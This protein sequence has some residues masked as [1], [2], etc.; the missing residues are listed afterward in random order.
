MAS[1][2]LMAI[3]AAWIAGAPVPA[4]DP[5]VEGSP[6]AGESSPGQPAIASEWTVPPD[7]TSGPKASA[8]LPPCQTPTATRCDPSGLSGPAGPNEFAAC[9]GSGSA[10]IGA[11][12]IDIGDLSLIQPMGL[13]IGGHVTPIDHG[14]F[15]IKGSTEA[16]PRRA[17][18]R[19]PFAGVITAVSR[20]TRQGGIDGAFDDY[21][22]TIEATCTFRARFSNMTG[23]TGGLQAAVGDL[24][25]GRSATPDYHVVE[26]EL[27][28]FTGLPTAYGIDV[29]IEDDDA[30]LTGFVN[31]DQY[32]QAEPWKL[33]MVDLFTY[34]K[35]PLRSQL[36]ALNMREALPAFGKI[37]HDIDGRLVGSWFRQGSGGYGGLQHGG[38]GYWVGHLSI[39]PDGNDP[40]QTIVSLGDFEGQAQQFAVIGNTP[41]PAT[42][43]PGTGPI[44]YELGQIVN[45]RGD[46]GEP[47]DHRSFIPHIRTRAGDWE[48]GT[49]LLEMTGP[50]RLRMEVFPGLGAADVPGFGPDALIYER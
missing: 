16:P 39:V 42:V 18:V 14:Y 26:G 19:S 15:Y 25:P 8:V 45:Y 47:W 34:T 10:L 22:V 49:V 36:L 13:M 37:D 7:P 30:T 35:E 48:V 31:A 29:W 2:V 4:R 33:H 24:P 44:R 21:A 41:D 40:S 17:G 20:T 6:R 3:A 50:R 27:I 23:F 11:S 46:T 28:G 1:L 5:G 9:I 12:P 38:E 43:S 32:T